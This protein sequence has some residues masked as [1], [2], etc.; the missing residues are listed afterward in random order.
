MIALP[1]VTVTFMLAEHEDFNKY[2]KFADCIIFAFL[3]I[4]KE[5]RFSFLIHRMLEKLCK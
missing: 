2:Q 4:K 3:F 5:L 1:E